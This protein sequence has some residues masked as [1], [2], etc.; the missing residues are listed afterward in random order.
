M[1]FNPDQDALVEALGRIDD[2]KTYIDVEVRRFDPLGKGGQVR[3]GKGE[4]KI[5]ILR[6][7]VKDDGIR[8]LGRL[9]IE[10]AAELSAMLADYFEDEA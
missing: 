6:R 4:A 2:G 8:K 9:R 3:E 7:S 1:S 5:S 10:V